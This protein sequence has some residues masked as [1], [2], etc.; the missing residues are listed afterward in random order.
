MHPILTIAIKAARRA[1][2]IIQRAS[3]NMESVRV[4]NKKHNDFVS[5]VDRAAEAAIIDVIMEAYP[6]HAILAE[7]SGAKGI[8]ESEYEW[9]IDPL[10]GTT[11][12]LHGHPQYCISIAMAH[13]G[14]I[15]QAVVYDPNRNELYSASRGVGSFMNDRRIRVSKRINM[16][17]CLISTGF[18]VVDQ[19]ML[20][21]HLAILKDVLGKTAGARREGSAALDLCNVAIGR[22]DG[23]FE[24]NLKP[25]DIAAGSLIVQEA[26]GIVTD[27][28]GEQTWLESGD[29]VAAPPKVLGQLLPIIGKHVK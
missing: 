9:I 13:R 1:G 4:E 28:H 5:D 27:M 26:G 18:P 11:N 3:L 29:I 24:F 16:N 2:N 20:D 21:T 10:D 6:K 17:E 8:G 14:Q 23:F 19:S 12:F 22:V 15:Q 7:E 25:W